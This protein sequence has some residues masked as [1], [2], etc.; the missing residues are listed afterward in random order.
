MIAMIGDFRIGLIS[1]IPNMAPILFAMG[2]MGF[3]SIPLGVYTLLVGS[4]AIG[5]AVDDTIHM[6]HSFVRF[7]REGFEPRQAMHKALSTS[8][9]AI[10]FTSA[11]L[12]CGFLSFGLA[13]LSSLL[14]FGI[15]ASIAIV[16][17]LAAD[18][19]LSPALFV[20]VTERRAAAPIDEET[21]REPIFQEGVAQG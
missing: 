20:W 12:V 15:V 18:L 11:A 4:I 10:L 2:M 8:G 7:E 1:F 21:T 19:I 13:S 9:V 16:A 17:A 14:H 6:A 3:L 5:L